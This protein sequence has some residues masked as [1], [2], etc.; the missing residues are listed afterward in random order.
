MARLRQRGEAQVTRFLP[1][2][3]DKAGAVAQEQQVRSGDA[4][5]Q[6][7]LLARAA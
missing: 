2:D 5:L 4:V 1:K 7:L 3:D 6:L